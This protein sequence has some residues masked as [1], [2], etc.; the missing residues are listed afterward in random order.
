MCW[1]VCLSV[2]R[3]WTNKEAG[4]LGTFLQGP[5]MTSVRHPGKSQAE[6]AT[7]L[8]NQIKIAFAMK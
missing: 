1:P 2:L 5:F 8:M 4:R 7:I 3:K 6:R